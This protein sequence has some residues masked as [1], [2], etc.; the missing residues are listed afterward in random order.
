MPLRNAKLPIRPGETAAGKGGLQAA[1]ANPEPVRC[2]QTK[3]TFVFVLE[4]GRCNIDECRSE[5]SIDLP[6]T[7]T[8]SSKHARAI[9]N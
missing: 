6:G 9:V 3:V 4:D 2:A 8:V 5:I 7:M 1:F